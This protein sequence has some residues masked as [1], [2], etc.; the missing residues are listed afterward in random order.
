MP[1]TNELL[2]QASQTGDSIKNFTDNIG[3]IFGKDG[4][5]TDVKV[6][7]TLNPETYIYMFGVGVALIFLSK[8]LIDPLGDWIVGLFK[9]EK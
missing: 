8:V 1:T 7:F 2:G 6:D 3:N 4:I 9:Y 5:K